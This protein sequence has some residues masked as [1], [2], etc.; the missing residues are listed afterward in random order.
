MSSFTRFD[1][2]LKLMYVGNK[3]WQVIDGFCYYLDRDKQIT[4]TVPDG[5]LT[6]GATVPRL[7]HIVL[8]PWGEYGQAAVLH[9]YTLETRRYDTDSNTRITR[10]EARSI[11]NEAMK[12]LKVPGYKRIPIVT[13]VYIW[14]K[15]KQCRGDK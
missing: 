2:Q 5:F 7:L 15:I 14:D 11:F 6:D 8:P 3:R 9:D 12:V 1:A 10:D 4:I 13:G